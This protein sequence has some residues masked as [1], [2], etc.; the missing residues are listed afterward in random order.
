MV[1][2]NL[3]TLAK[4]FAKLRKD[5]KNVLELPVGPQGE[6]GDTG[7]KGLPGDK[8]ERGTD[9]RD[10]KDGSSGL[11]GLNGV[12]GK[13]G[14]DGVDGKDGADG[15][16][17]VDAEI[18]VDGSLIFKL[19]DGK[20]IDVGELSDGSR[21]NVFV[22]GAPSTGGGAGGSTTTTGTATIDFGAFPGSNEASVTVTGQT[23]ITSDSVI[24]AYV[25]ADDTSGTHTASDH[26]YF[27]VFAELTCSNPSAGT[28]FTIYA[29]STEK[30]QGTFALRWAWS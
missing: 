9:G 7:D 18:A 13:D 28:G 10:G 26:R 27:A 11:N 12:N 15:V 8:G 22:S 30:L 4:E 29:R 1:D 14:K 5:V 25:G 2:T 6:K 16:S 21:N 17:V 24:R 23:D 19:S 3:L 20:I